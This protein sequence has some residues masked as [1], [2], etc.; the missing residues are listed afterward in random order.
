MNNPNPNLK[1]VVGLFGTCGDSQ[2]RTPVIAKLE[3]A[4][5]AFFNPQLAPGTWTEACA[6]IE[7]EHLATDKVI[8]LVIS[9]ETEA[10][11]SMAETGFAALSAHKNGQ[12]FI[13]VVEDF[14][15][16]PKSDVNRAR[17]LIRAHA[18]TAGIALFT[19]VDEGVEATLAA[20]QA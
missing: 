3:A 12:N 17:K 8:L 7:A 20:M 16:D 1:N 4:G 19:S 13:L 5:I 6:A 10:L 11:G 15:G 18:K 9:K 14:P 2:W